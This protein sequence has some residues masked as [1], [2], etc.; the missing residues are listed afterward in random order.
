MR[1][2]FERETKERD[3]DGLLTICKRGKTRK[4]LLHL[5]GY[6][7]R[8]QF[9]LQSKRTFMRLLV[10]RGVVISF[11]KNN[12]EHKKDMIVELTDLGRSIVSIIREKKRGG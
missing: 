4:F 12:H 9:S 10:K 2:D 3:S 1:S 11:C 5:A 7:P 6:A 8:A